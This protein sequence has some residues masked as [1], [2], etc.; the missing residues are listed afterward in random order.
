MPQICENWF[1]GKSE[2][3]TMSLFEHIKF[4]KAAFT[5]NLKSTEEVFVTL[6]TLENDVT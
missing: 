1:H 3:F 5:L 2:K 4:A 6:Q